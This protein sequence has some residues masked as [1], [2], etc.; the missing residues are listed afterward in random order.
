M[1]N[2]GY[3][4][5]LIICFSL[6][7]QS[8]T[9]NIK[10]PKSLLEEIK[11]SDHVPKPFVRA[12]EFMRQR[13]YPYEA[14][15]ED[16]RIKAIQ[17]ADRMMHSKNSKALIQAQQPE[18][19]PIGPFK[20][21]GRIKSIAPH[22]V[23]NGWAYAG[24]AAGGIWRTTD[25]GANW[26]P[27][28]DFENGIAFGS[29]AIDPNHPDTMYAGTG[30]AVSSAGGGL[31]GTP[32][33]LGAGL[34]K[35]IDAG[36]T[37]K[38][39][40]LRNVGTFS[41]VYVHPKNSN[42]IVAGGCYK[43]Q[44]FYKSTDAGATWTK[45]FDQ[46]VTDVTID[47]N[48]ENWIFI[49]VSSEGVYY[50]SDAGDNWEIRSSGFETGIGRVSVQLA[51]SSPETLYSLTDIGGVGTIY[52][53]TNSGSSWSLIYKGQESFFNGQGWYDNYISVHPSNANIVLAGG[54]DIWRTSDGGSA[55][56]N[57]TS[58]YT[59]GSVHVDQHVASFNPLN[60]NIVYAGNDGGIYISSN[61]GYS[62]SEINNNLQVTQF[63]SLAVDYSKV[64][65][66][67]GGTQDNGTLGNLT[68]DNWS[69]IIGGDGF[70]VIVDYDNPNIFYGESQYGSIRRV[71]LA[72]MSSKSIESGVFSGDE[73]P[74]D[75]PFI[76]DP[77]NNYILYHG[78]HALYASYDNG[79]SWSKI[80]SK[81]VPGF[82]TIAVSHAN[83]LVIWAG[84]QVG[85]LYVCKDG[86]EKGD[87]SWNEVSSN[88]LVNRYMT[89]IETSYENEG[90]AYVSY[91]GYGAGHI[92]K[93][94]DYGQT[95]ENIG[96][97]LPDAPCNAIALH[98]ENENILFVATDVGVFTT[99]DAGNSWLPFGSGLPRSPVLDL[100]FHMNR[101]VLPDLILR[102]AT[103]GRSMWEVT[104]PSEIVSDL[105]ITSPAGGEI[106]VGTSSSVISWYGFNQPVKIEYSTNDGANWV[107][108]ANNVT[109]NYMRWRVP[110]IDAL[111]CRIRVS[112]NDNV[113]ISRTFS[114]NTL[115]KGSVLISSGVKYVPYGITYDGINGLWSTDFEGNKLYKLN[116][117]TF[118]IEKSFTLPGDSLFSD[119][120][121]D[122]LT[123]TIYIHKMNSTSGNGG[124]I[125]VLD[126]LGNQIRSF[127]SPS[128][129]YPIGLE[130]VDGVLIACDRDGS[131]QMYKISAVDGSEISRSTNPYNKTYGP[132]G[133]CY[134]GS[135]Y[136]YQI[137]TYFPGGGSLTEALAMKIDKDTLTASLE[138]MPLES[139][140][141]GM[142]NARG[143]DIDP[144]DNNFWVSDYNGN[145]Y[146]IAGFN[147]LVAD[148]SVLSNYGNSPFEVQFTDNSVGN[149]T[150]W[151]WEF[152]DGGTSTEK[153]PIH[154]YN[155]TGSF[156]VKLTVSDGSISNMIIKENYIIVYD[157]ALKAAFSAEPLSGIKPLNV[158]FTDNSSGQITSWLWNFG[159]GGTSSEKNPSHIYNSS[160]S[161][162][163]TLKITDETNENTTFKSNYIIVLDKKPIA[164]FSANPYA[165]AVPLEVKFK[166]ESE[167][168]IISWLW[169]FGDGG[170]ST[171]KNPTHIFQDTGTYTIILKTYGTNDS[172]EIIKNNFI[173]VYPPNILR[174]IFSADPVRG[175]VPFSVKF[176][177]QSIGNPTTWLWD[178]GDDSSSTEQ[179]P[180]HLYTKSNIYTVVLTVS[181]GINQSTIN[182]GNYIIADTAVGV[183]YSLTNEIGV[184]ETILFPNP[185][186]D[187]SIIS[188]KSL[189][190]NANVKVQISDVL[191]R[192]IGTYFDGLMN[193]EDSHYFQL[194]KQQLS[195]GVYFV[196][197][198]VN[199]RQA[200]LKQLIVAE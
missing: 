29:I 105:A 126:T 22:P 135:K 107:N 136:L 39:I 30:E 7:L 11:P 140:T 69:G 116:A 84:N 108:I 148:F 129:S 38:L 156:N 138:T 142:I 13:A 2:F 51:P 132:R 82:S 49:G 122:R 144:R 95:W 178:F 133:L 120:T 25:Y 27:I 155:S 165:G 157:N 75:S 137:C 180:V 42:F 37:W 125:L 77:I 4:I 78:R 131:R 44:G 94:T 89:D 139:N 146:K 159:D 36:V 195:S 34:F 98:P 67:F 85:E 191:G 80:I 72:N 194:R 26:T 45:T 150:S 152:G 100:S 9:T 46:N 169:N 59:G 47:P 62:W 109:G 64:N 66:N 10:Y 134:D 158:Q 40:G 21:G 56:T 174:A 123:G 60:P 170:T 12:H 102:A 88:G 162:T 48:D 61:S 184:L 197:F 23:K 145:L 43:G 65:R 181:D 1:K 97:S 18:W 68:P 196:S 172:S 186:L 76:M 147:T 103:H 73:G 130:L 151:S 6:S 70:R 124:K 199:G 179:N 96:L 153:N 154:I 79:D 24:A 91:S 32:I 141:G 87:A 54:I 63:Y 112:A 5:L 16:A 187:F 117:E 118:A 167:G 171:E 164:A 92:F 57:V 104:V 166:D 161:F 58:G 106:Y 93:T 182:M 113:V 86:A 15:P 110:N 143:I 160:G 119:L 192:C 190:D 83:Q 185:M 177:D 99:Y 176:T 41:K 149:I 74:W 31:G 90:T 189:I 114:I 183:E 111:L 35:S 20:V 19:K 168:N 175:N 17:Y 53:T 121:L 115:K 71:N 3:L 188:F 101:L 52:K 14:V 28:F 50:S 198:Y 193:K 200:L 55:W 8:Q 173:K 128:K 33:Y 127:N 163:V 81:K